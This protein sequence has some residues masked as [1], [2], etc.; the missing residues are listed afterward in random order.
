MLDCHWLA[1]VRPERARKLS[2]RLRALVQVPHFIV[3]LAAAIGIASALGLLVSG[4]HLRPAAIGIVV[5]LSVAAAVPRRHAVAAALLLCPALL[6]F[7]L[8][9]DFA[10]ENGVL[11][12]G[13]AMLCYSLGRR[14]DQLAAGL[15]TGCLFACCQA[16]E[17]T[18]GDPLSPPFLFV[19]FGSFMLGGIVES[20]H[21]LVGE[22]AARQREVSDELETYSALV[23]SR[24]RA[25]IARELHDIV[26]HCIA[27]MVIQAGA[28]RL[29][30]TAS[31]EQATAAFIRIR[32]AGSE[33]LA[34][35]QKLVDMLGPEQAGA[36]GRARLD[37]LMH[38]VQAA[39]LSVNLIGADSDV[40]ETAFRI[41]QEG[42]TNVLKHAP[43]SPVTVS[44][45]QLETEVLIEIT[46]ARMSPGHP[47]IGFETSRQGLSGIRERVEVSGGELQAGP[48]PD[49]GWQLRVRLPRHPARGN[50]GLGSGLKVPLQSPTTC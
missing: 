38:Q 26:A 7:G 24:E 40:D 29:T 43:G 18:V 8:V 41:V 25:R 28:G 13:L 5:A 39:G 11:F 35:M 22:M 33:A 15:A 30:S 3:I 37:A 9:E 36:D 4:V 20:R 14:P 27:V 50:A 34:E 44:F 19:T 48:L 1:P 21:L 2:A 17:V 45:R 23:V 6:A 16:L 10:S 32:E 42:L 12:L 49:G 46:N 47:Q 31:R